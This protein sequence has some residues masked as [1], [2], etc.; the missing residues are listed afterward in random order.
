MSNIV[1]VMGLYKIL[2]GTTKIKLS[3]INSILKNLI[4]ISETSVFQEVLTYCI[5]CCLYSGFLRT[6]T[7]NTHMEIA[8]FGA[9]KGEFDTPT[10]ISR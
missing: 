7:K 9:P 3:E 8:L 2:D 4:I 5:I 1:K 10:S 6:T